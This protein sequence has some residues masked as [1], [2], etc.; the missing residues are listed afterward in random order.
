[1][2]FDHMLALNL[3]AK[4]FVEEGTRIETA[5]V[6]ACEWLK[7]LGVFSAS[8]RFAAY[9][10]LFEDFQRERPESLESD[11]GFLNYIAA[12]GEASELIRIRKW[13]GQIDS[14]AYLTQLRKVT[15]GKAF[16]S[17]VGADPARD[18]AFEL[19]VAARFLAAGYPV[20]VTSIADTV[21]HVGQHK[22]YVECKRVQSPSKVFMRLAEARDQLTIHLKADISSKSR[23]LVACRITEVLNPEGRIAIFADALDFR[24]AG[25]AALQDYARANEEKLRR[26][27]GKKQLG[28]L[29]ENSL[30]GVVYNQTDPNSEPAFMNCR[31]ATFYYYGLG[32]RDARLV[33]DMAPNLSNQ[34]VL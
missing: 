18:F 14:S 25:E 31:G 30:H 17:Q 1:M 21:A 23:G 15:S 5:F 28:I 20:D 7:S 6:E 4:V 29:F 19:A 8:N 10:K 9:L 33:T 12:L 27:S 16:K 24:R 11:E 34:H 22:I 32:E 26:C 13:M 2:R 3:P